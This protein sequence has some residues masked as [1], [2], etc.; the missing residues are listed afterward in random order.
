MEKGSPEAKAW[1]R[2][3]RALRKSEKS[4]KVNKPV[5]VKSP[6]VIRMSNDKKRHV[7]RKQVY[8]AVPDLLYAGSAVELLGPAAQAVWESRSDLGSVNTTDL[9]K[10]QIIPQVVPA[11]ELA[12]IGVVVQKAAKWLG[13]NKFG[14]KDV[15]VF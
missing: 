9:I 5:S 14:T 12:V 15:K 6:K 2:R 11:A 10:Y 7:K 8:H 4:Q 3:M 13:L 1:G